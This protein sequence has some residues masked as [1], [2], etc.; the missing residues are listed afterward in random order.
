M[1]YVDSG[2]PIL[3]WLGLAIASNNVCVCGGGLLLGFHIFYE[4][5]P[6]G[7]NGGH[8]GAPCS[9]AN[10]IGLLGPTD[11]KFGGSLK[12]IVCFAALP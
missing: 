6:T 12:D 7:N 1:F 10:R 5:P 9:G 3:Y 8:L 11:L 4:I 2:S